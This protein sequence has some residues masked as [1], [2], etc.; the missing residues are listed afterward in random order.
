MLCAKRKKDIMARRKHPHRRELLLES[1]EDR[2]LCDAAPLVAIEQHTLPHANSTIH[3]T[4]GEKTAVPIAHPSATEPTTSA[5]LTDTQRQAIQDVVRD[6]TAQIWFEKNA[7]QF[8]EGV[9]FGFRTSFGSMMVYDDH[10]QIRANQTDPQTGKVGVHTVN[11]SFTGSNHSWQIVPGES[12]GVGGS[13][14]NADGTI[15]APDIFK[16]LTIRNVYEGVD[17]RLYSADKGTL[18]FDWLVARAQDYSKIR[19][20]FSGQDGMTFGNDGSMSLDLRFQDLSLKL[21][22][23]YQLVGGVKQ[24]HAAR[25]VAGTAPGEVR[26]AIEGDLVADAPLVIDPN[27]AWATYFDLND[28]TLPFDSYLFAVTAG[29][30][31]VYAFGWVKETITNAANGAYM[32]VPAGFSQGTAANQAYIYRLN[33]SGTNITA[34]TGTGITNNDSTVSNQALNGAGYD[35]PA[36]LEL[37]PDGRI[38]AGFN[39]GLIQIYSADLATRSYS[40]EPVTMDSLNS[41]AIVDNSSF[42][43]G[44]RVTAAIP[45]GQIAAANI[46]PDATFAGTYEGVIVRYSNA[47]TTPTANW[48]TYVGGNNSEYFTAIALTPDKT[49]LVFATTTVV[50]AAYPT[51]VNA[52]DSTLGAAGTTELL[53]GVLPEQATKPAAFS[54]FSY[55]GGSGNEG[56]L[57]TNTTAAVVT[58]T[59][60]FFYVAGNTAS[61]DLPGVTAATGGAGNGAQITNGGGNFDAFISLIP[62]NGSAGAGFQSTYVGGNLE[63]NIGGIAYDIRADRVLLFG[64][65]AGGTFPVLNTTPPSNYYD[66]TFGGGAWDIFVAT[67]TGNLRT[68]DFAT[69]IGG[70]SNDYLGQTGDLIG[71]GH[72]IYSAVTGLTYLATTVHSAD[73]PTS[74]I[75]TPPG[76]DTSKS[77]GTNDSHV[78]FAFNLNIFDYGDAPLTYDVNVASAAREGQSN[79][80]RLGALTD[81]ESA[82]ASGVTATGDD[83]LNSGTGDDEDAISVIPA[84]VVGDTGYSLSVSVFNNTG[85]ARTLNAWID[86]NRNGTFE[87]GEFATVSVPSSALQQTLTLAWATLPA[88][89]AGQSYIRLRL[90]DS[91][92]TDN[93]GTTTIDERSI[94]TG[95]FGEIEDYALT[96]GA[97]PTL[98]VSNV[99]TTEGT[100]NFAQFAVNLSSASSSATSL[101]FSLA[102]VTATGGGTDYGAGGAGNLQVST[103]GGVTWAN[104]TTVT[105]PAGAT[106]VLVRTPIVN[107]TLDENAETFTL[108]ATR[109]A[110]NTSNASAIGTATINDDDP[111][112]TIVINDVTVNE[113]AGTMT[114]TATLSAA[115]GLPVSVNYATSNGSATAGSDY[116]AT[117]G[118]LNFASGIVS[119]TITV[120]IANDTVFEGSETFNV[121]LSAAVNATIADNLGIGTI[122]DD[123]TGAG[124]TDND[125]PVLSV[126]SPT[127]TEGT[128]A[129]AIFTV[130]LS[131][132]STTAV[133]L[134]LALAN[135]S[136]LG[137]GVDYGASLEVSTNG[138]ATWTTASAATIAAGATSVLVRTPIVNDAL[139]EAAETFT[140]T[141]TRTAGTTTN[142]SATGTAT[143]VD[144]DPTPTLVINDVTV[145][146]GAGTMTFIVTLSAPSGQAVSVNYATLNGTA[147]AGADYTASSGTVNF[148]LGTTTQTIT[149]PI[150]ND[151]I[152]EQSENFSVLLSG[153]VNVVVA[154]GTGIGTILDDGTGGGATDNDTPVISVSNIVVTEGTDAFAIFTVS[155]SNPSTGTVSVNLALAN[156]SALG[157]GVDY[158]ASL[159]VSTNGGATWTTASAAT[160]AAGATSVL[161][162]TPIVN[163]ALNEASETFTLTATRT[164][165]TTTNAIAVGTAT[166][167]D[168]DPQPAFA[169]NDVTVNEAAGTATF[170]VTLSA[171]SGQAVS[172]NYATSNG[173]ALA[174]SDYTATSGVL[175]FAAGVT[176]QT[177]TVAITNDS[178]FEQSE[179]FNLNLSAAVNA[180]IADNLGIG[181]IKDDGTGAGGADNDTPTISVGNVTVTE[182]TDA[183][184]IF[185]VSLSNASATPVSVNLALANGSALGGGVDYG[186]SLEVSTNGG[187]TWTT[188]SAATIAAGSTSVLVRTPIVND[189]INEASETFT[190]TA[191]RTAGTTTNASAVGTATIVDNDPQPSFAINDVTVNEAAGTMTFTV[192]LSAPS[193][194]A[195]SVNYATSDGTALAGSDYAAAGGVL[196]F[197]AGVTSQTVTVSI[198]ND[199]I[200]EVVE[201]FRVNLSGAVN[202]TIAD[203]LGIGTIRDDGTGAGGTDNDTPTIN[204]ANVLVT[205]GTDPYAIFTVSLS[206]ASTAPVS[207]NLVLANGSALGGGVDYGASLEVSTDGGATWTTASSATIAAGSTS[208]LV[209]TPI[210]DDA[211]NE[212]AETF[213]LTAIRTAGTTTN[214]SVT[215]TATIADNDPKPT[216]T[217]NDVIVNE[218]AGT[219]TFTV[220]LSAPSGQAVS[221]SY[222]TSDGTAVVVNDYTAASGTLN[223]AP[224]VT[225]QTVTISIVDDLLFENSETFN[226][227][228]SGA[229]NA[230]LA[231]NL[232][233]GTIKDDGTGI[234][235]TNNDTPVLSVSSVTV[236]EGTDLYAVF[237][238]SL[239]N[240]STTAVGLNLA[241]GNVTATGGGSDYGTSGAGNLQVSMD[242]GA[243]WIDASS[244]TI[245]AGTAGFLARTPVANDNISEPIETFTL[246]ATVTSGT[247]TTPNATGTALVLDDE[248]PPWVTIDDVTVNEAAGNAVFTVTLQTPSSQTVT[249]DYATVSG[250][251]TAGADF[252]GKTGTLTFAPGVTTL[253]ISVPI[254]NDPLYEV[255]ENFTV[256]LSGAVHATVLDDTG[257]GTILDDGTGAGGTDDDMPSINVS[258]PTVTEGTN[259]FAVFTVSL[260]NPSTGVVSVN[261]ALT[262]GTATGLGTDYGPG[263][264]ISTD[265]GATW[266]SGSNATFAAG[267]TTVLARTA[268]TDDALD[269]AAETFTLTA[270]RSGGLTTNAVASGTA[271]ILDNDPTP[272][273]TI[274]DVTVNEAAGT[275]TFTVT[276]SAA[277]GQAVSVAY[278]TANGTATSG[279]DYSSTSGTLNFA[280]GVVS[281]TIVVSIA[282]DAVFEGSETFDVNLS[283][284]VNATI[285]DALGLGTI[286]DDGT[287]SGGVD[288]DTP[289][290]SVSSPTV[291]EGTD[292]FAVFTVSL[293]NAST[294]AVDLNLALA[295]G[296]ATGSD[297]GPGL[298]VSTDGGTT[299]TTASSATMAAGSMSL[300]VRTPITNDALDEAAETFTLTATRT[301][302]TTTN[303]SASGIGTIIDDDPTPSFTIN[304]VTV[305]E[306]TGTATFTVTLSAASGQAVSVNYATSD[307]SALAGADYT[308]TSGTL[309]FAT[310]VVS[311]TITVSILDDA[312]FENSEDFLVTLSGPVNATIVDNLGIGTIKD[313][314][315][316]TGGTDNDTPAVSVSNPNVREGTDAFAVFTVSLSHPSTTPVDVSL[317]LAN[318]TA[319]GG[320]TDFGA[321]MEISTDGGA[322]W[323]SGA[324][325]TFAAGTTDVLVRTP[326]LNDAL[327][328]G[329]ENFTLAATVTSGTT[330]NASATGTATIA[331]DDG[332]PTLSINDVTVN[333][334]AGTMTFTVTMS[335][336]SGLPV[337]VNYATASGT[338]TAGADFTSTSGTLIFAPGV[339]TRTIVVPILNDTIFENSESFSVLLSA[340]VNGAIGD[341]T[342]IGTIKDDGTGAGGVD[343]DTPALSVSNVAVTEGTN[344][345]AVFTVSLSNPS[346]TAVT[347]SLALANVSALGG[348]TD[349]GASGATNLQVST[350]GGTTWTNAT[351]ATI[352]A[353]STSVLVRTPIVDD[354]LDENAETFTLTA[355]VTSGT[356][357]GSPVTGTATITDNDPTPSL[358]INDV[359]VN[360]AAGT[361]TFTVTLSAPSGL[362]ASVNYTTSNGTATAGSDYTAVSGTLNFAPGTTTQTITVPILNDTIFEQSETFNVLLSGAVN[363]TIADATGIGTIKDDGTGTGGTDN[364]KPA[365]SVSNVTVLEGTDN[366]AVFTVNLG[367]TSTTPVTVSLAL[368]NGTATGADYGPAIQVSTDGGTTWTTTASA[369]IAAGSTSVLVRTPIVNDALD[370]AAETF[371]LI[372]TRTAGTTTNAS[373]TG[374]ATI[375]DDDP[376]PTMTVNDVTVNEGAGTLTFTVTLSAPSGQAVSVNYATASGT[377]TSGAD[378]TSASGTLNFALGVT[379]RTIT[380]PIVNDTLFEQSENFSLLLSSAVNATITDDTGI[381]TI[382]DDGTGPGGTN[383]DT[384]SITVSNP[385]ALEG[386]DLFAVFNVKLSNPSTTA[387]DVAFALADGTAVGGGT[388]YGST[389]EVSTDGG[390]TWT[391]AASATFAPGSTSVLVRT[392]VVDDALD[393]AA[394]TFTLT[395]T[396]TAGLTTNASA[397]GTGTIN[398]DDPPPT[399]TI[400]DVIVNEAAGFATFTVSLNT[401][402]GQGVSVNFATASGTATSGADFTS[403]SG[404]L[405]FVAGVTTQTIDVPI[406][407]DSVFEKTESFSVLLTGPVHATI[408]DNL[409]VGTILDDGTGPGGTDDDTPTIVVSNVTV[410]EGTDAYAVFAVSLSNPVKTAIT[411]SFTLADGTAVGGGTDYGATLEVSDDGGATWTTMGDATFPPGSTSVLV[412]TPIT[413]DAL[414]EA[415]ENF[416]LTATRTAGTTTNPSAVGVATI[417]DNDP[418]PTIR[419]ND[420]TV[421]EAAG[422]A[423]FTVSLNAPSGQAVSVNYATS[424][425]TATAGSDYTAGSG[426]LNF[427][428]GVTSQT[429]TISITNDTTFEVSENF[430]VNLSSAVRATIADNLGVGTIL[431]DGTGAGGTDNDTPAITVN[432]VSVTE[433]TNPYAVFSVSLSNP[434]KT[435][436]SVS[437]ALANGSAVGGG[438]DF[439][440]ALEVSTN[441]GTTWVAA[442]NATIAAGSTSVL[443]R[444]PIV[445]DALDEAAET[446]TLTATR[447]VG[448]TTN[449]SAI[450][451]ATII[452]DDPPPTFSITDV[453][454][455]EGA[456]TASFVVSLNTP[457]GQ[458]VSV[459]YLTNDGTAL[460]GS[461]YTATSGVLNFT[462]GVTSQTVTV[463]IAND[464][465]FEQSEAFSVMLNGAVNATITKNLGI[466]IILDDGTGA[467]GTDNDT[468]TIGVTNVTVL[469][470]TDP[471][472][473]FAVSLSRVS[474]TAVSVNLALAN[475][476]ATGG[477]VDFGAALEV[478]SDGGTTWVSASSV[479]FSPG[480]TS[481]LV[482]TPIT[483]DALNEAAETFTL[484]ATRTAGTTINPSA[485]GT[486]T[487]TDNDPQP[488]LTIDD[489]VVNEGIGTATF[490]V[491]MSA[492]SGQAVSVNYATANGT[493]LAGTDFAAATGTLTFPAGSL[494]QTVTIPIAIFNDGIFEG[495]EN[496]SM[497]LS[498]AVNATIADGTGSGTILDAGNGTG[499]VDND[500]PS[501]SVGNAVALEGTDTHLVF[502]V[503]LT[504]PSTTAVTVNLALANGTATGGGV[505]FGP[506][507][508]VSTDGGTTWT[509]ASSATFAPLAT[510]VLVR[511]PVINDAL[512]EVAENLTLT[513]TRTAGTT[514]NASATGIGTITDDDGPPDLSI[515]DVTVNEA[516][517]TAT[518]T[519][520]LSVPSGQAVS[521]NF[522]SVDGTAQS[523]ADYTGVS[524]TLNFAA[525]VTSQTITVP[526]LNDVV[527]ERSENFFIQLSGAVN[528]P[529][530]DDIGVGTILDDGTG[531]G[532]TDNDTPAISVSSPNVT[533]GANPFA[534]FTVALSRAST[535]PV[536]ASF[537]LANG[538]AN[539]G[540]DFGPG[541][542]VSLD[543]GATWAAVANATFAP[544]NT[545]VLVRTPVINDALNEQTETFQLTATRTAGTT[546]NASATGTGTIADDDAPPAILINDVTVNEA[547]GTA[548]F[549]VTL[550]VPSALAVSVNYATANGT[551]TAGA[552]FSA[553]SG[554]LNFAAGVTSQTITVPILNDTIFEQS[555]TFNVL[556]SAAVNATIADATGVG[557]IV[558]DGTGAGG[559]DN[560]TPSLNVVNVT[561]TEG[562]NPY[563]V[564]T[565]SLSNAST[566]PVSV[567]LALATGTA[568]GADFGPGLEVSTNGG[569][570]W[571]VAANATI[572]P[573]STS[574]LVRTPVVND[575]LDENAEDFTLTAT[576]TAGITTNAGATGTGTILDDDPTPSLNV[577]SPTVLEGTDTYAIFTVSLSSR[578]GAPVDVNLALA[579]GTATGGGTDFGPGLEVST[580]GGA[581]W[582]ASASATIASGTTSVLV[583]TPIADDALNEGTENFTLTA[584]RSAGTTLNAAATGTA[585]ILDDDGPPTVSIGDVTVNESA[586]TATFAVTLSKVSG[587]AIAVDYASAD[588]SARNGSDYAGVS[589]T[590]NFAT[591]VTSLT[592]VVPI[593]N[594]ARYENRETFDINLSNATN[595]LIADGTGVGTVLDDDLPQIVKTLVATSSTG[596]SGPNVVP[597]EVVTFQLQFELAEGA[598]PMVTLHD[599]L[600]AGL[601]MLPDAPVLIGFTNVATSIGGRAAGTYTNTTDDALISASLTADDDNFSDGTGVFFKLGTLTNNDHDADREFV[602]VQFSA[603]VTNSSQNQ[604]GF[605]HANNF[606]ALLDTNG[607]GTTGYVSVDRNGDNSATGTEVAA[608][609]AN[610]GSGTAGVSKT[611]T[612]TLA[613]AVLSLQKQITSAPAVIKAGDTLTYTITVNHAVGSNA[614][615]WDAT[616]S[617]AIPAGMQVTNI[618]STTVAGGASVQAPA[619]ISGGGTGLDGVFDIPV[620]GSVTVV[621][622]ATVQSSAVLGS[623]LNNVADLTWSSLAGV[624]A[625]ERASGDGLLNAGGLNDYE[626]QRSATA[627]V[628]DGASEF[629]I[630]KRVVGDLNAEIGERLHFSIT[631]NVADGV[632]NNLSLADALPAGFQL[633]AGSASLTTS[634]G[635]SV[636]SA[637]FTYAASQLDLAIGSV[638]S[639]VDGRANT[640][641]ISYDADVLDVAGNTGAALKTN[642]ATASYD[643]GGGPIVRTD[644]ETLTV[645][646][647]TLKIVKTMDDTTPHFGQVVT[648]TITITHAPGSN[649]A[650]HDLVLADVLPGEVS[651]DAASIQVSGASVVTNTSVNG[652]SLNLRLDQLA[653]GGTATITYR[654]KVT[655]DPALI[656]GT[657]GGGDDDFT[658]S[659]NLTYDTQAGTPV[660]ER[661][662]TTSTSGTATLVGADLSVTKDDGHATATPGDRLVYTITVTNHGTAAATNVI[663]RDTLPPQVAT[664]N[665]ALSSAGAVVANGVA[666]F[667]IPSLAAGAT[668]TLTVV[669]DLRAGAP[670]GIDSFTNVVN[671]THADLDPTPGDNT[672]SDNDAL[673]AAPDYTISK[674]DGRTQ[675]QPGDTLVYTITVANRGN[676]AGTGIIVRD[677]FATGI[678]SSVVAS[679]G[680]AVDLAAG[681]VTWDLAYLG[682]GETR[683]LSLTARVRSSFGDFDAGAGN[684]LIRDTATVRDDGRNGID[685]TPAGNR[686]TDADDL[687]AKPELRVTND[688]GVIVVAP[689]QLVTYRIVAQNAGGQNSHGTVVVSALPEGVTFVSATSTNPDLSG[690]PTGFGNHVLWT[691]TRPLAPGE[692]VE[693]AIVVRADASLTRGAVLA[694]IAAISDDG[695]YGPDALSVADNTATD[696]D[697][698]MV[699]PPIVPFVYAYDSF[700]DFSHESQPPGVPRDGLL[701]ENH[702]GVFNRPP[703]L[704][705]MPIYS[706]EADPGATLVVSVFNV[707]GE[708][709]GSQTVVVDAGGNWMATFPSTTLNDFPSHVQ[710]TE[711]PAPYS[712]PDGAGHNLRTYFSPAIN[713]GHFFTESLGTDMLSGR[714]APLLGGLGLENPLQLGSVKYGGELLGTQSTASG[715]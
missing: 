61:T 663:V 634:T 582:T 93:A 261:L 377:A 589:G 669:L 658:N 291:T 373:A 314:G 607:D 164:A 319:T 70:S 195:A 73:I 5:P 273:L 306:A 633:V 602:T 394:E 383:N 69:Y 78:V 201:N 445:N 415:S 327:N 555:E 132:A 252:T 692:T 110:G 197:A 212:A 395:A 246:T 296:T 430:N 591:G 368:A 615:A 452:D 136:A 117:N 620:G 483:D 214:A 358:V 113:A 336:S 177:V 459:N 81:T 476:S 684:Q 478:S 681:T 282:N 477:G 220:L 60:S 699:E 369:T 707:R 176:T 672:A 332:P 239:S 339:L 685:P 493:A 274:N 560:D 36:D 268:I 660:N 543:G 670:A 467:G 711:I 683:S 173:T 351:T 140:L 657:F 678:F 153:P 169:I 309:N 13:Y 105:L 87:V 126:S 181:T 631:V 46:G 492:P 234:G 290:I 471:Y 240:L 202:A 350:N 25:M 418:P 484:T 276:L 460:A 393:E 112:P 574:V 156:G 18:E 302:G 401:P 8:A 259:A 138:G 474:T 608:D 546:T 114:F 695:R 427:A 571:V 35:T 267:T 344:P 361:M 190:L 223:F 152:F 10:L 412:R 515:N 189:A 375:N 641:T 28:S 295:D 443:V 287:G 80:L 441:G 275:A 504:N 4:T 111:T 325:A 185:T 404:T 703:L 642:T 255:S 299:W 462:P 701:F 85:A 264:E 638:Q 77:N 584:T 301:A 310:G 279:A 664:L 573:G 609:P 216:L 88:L 27:V 507:L 353:G 366:F 700:H 414:N 588:G 381:G 330:T 363:A 387:V 704:P 586:G 708:P 364:D 686:A 241:L 148:A 206:N 568:S 48:A 333:E 161:V 438:V 409:G 253:T 115:S 215:G 661:T 245:A 640:L 619:I 512:D 37:F 433:G 120:P 324:S 300:L 446:F 694:N 508:Q 482:R 709:I 598:N 396:R 227:N 413:D 653:V 481:V 621:Y 243:T 317:A 102:N 108:T 448:T 630:D 292:A 139:D 648:Y 142:A 553:R 398:D 425:G 624:D 155:L 226:V 650:A 549:T 96:I 175:N 271:T 599:F 209:R 652:G 250:T 432:S 466:G 668:T 238:V 674:T 125:T 107:D 331:D 154:D 56:T 618:V 52:I 258:S 548:T 554:T 521:V 338:A 194:Q 676:Q 356:A 64:T 495:S 659:V 286:K 388:D 151:A 558:D 706:G 289:T 465:I 534:V 62:L 486:A 163:D 83:L 547:A 517:G 213:T 391:A 9:R 229:V 137:G 461:D 91:A 141:A 118:T 428:P 562:A 367:N 714:A 265:G 436:V 144:D 17:L 26:Y 522:A 527:F 49:K 370:E 298:E 248:G 490:T 581:T 644:S 605:A 236:T 266:T 424:N 593:T 440:P 603:L 385:T 496:F 184:A 691:F 7:G 294:T 84:L 143:I 40:A 541:L 604:A 698:A 322:T 525:G 627:T 454:V 217:I 19:M 20:V 528:A 410:A 386:T 260:S 188:A 211:L 654:A 611:V 400:D 133:S 228:L 479:T 451:T 172:V 590:L 329:T 167:T 29:A 308:G 399:I 713:P 355:A 680:G 529:I 431:D 101:S 162:R 636:T 639:A 284:V 610:D 397:V 127:V 421:N 270:T 281:Q 128:D 626:L 106:S 550:N 193:G 564:F 44:G 315:T 124:G 712:L 196:N 326:I 426:V 186:A 50:G 651:L 116:T 406:V 645:A 679:D 539:S 472:A 458:P 233:V 16:E 585:T 39:S 159:E 563:A 68:K 613:E 637:N 104:G 280:P 54:V 24:T 256:V 347:A 323:T 407:N 545:S 696:V 566:T 587:L 629:A 278:A 667:T 131:N 379:T 389:L 230:T 100:D 340:V 565:V 97:Q 488:S 371:T 79:A 449:A 357:T 502:T 646:E 145:N 464:A 205:E 303:A 178:V 687:V 150:L 623:A 677:T 408:A 523:T 542:E 198:T 89:T 420:V 715:Y 66:G 580:D 92:L 405:N 263:L 63:D 269:E 597:G 42:Y 635:V 480:S 30:N 411:L 372:A 392:P 160:I 360:E 21:P 567:S 94:G 32:E 41:L 551:A 572:A 524:G 51:L 689:G 511:T 45:V 168:N 487:I 354:A 103:D 675:A 166:I 122:K 182:G 498:N 570:T 442:A 500:T 552:D 569:T 109:T 505:D 382:L 455:N 170:T 617:D 434:S 518:F 123:G 72:V 22:E 491:T 583:R 343:N 682:S 655:S 556:L 304:D 180:T 31:G 277:S 224:G 341:N 453:T 616:L 671:V 134:N 346:T 577:S 656:G 90:T 519:V 403:T 67:F 53:V 335:Q 305:N 578:S 75:G 456:G 662:S 537:A 384:P 494:V 218:G 509:T 121:N 514:L 2:I 58:A 579:N 199:T 283:G 204:V 665:R 614:T 450:G 74:A 210:T 628:G 444:T 647:P 437:L 538:T 119:Q 254:V 469:E 179:T 416:T 463:T 237:S 262:N 235:G 222:A 422:T 285:A 594:D 207:V 510:T 485:T 702:A 59:D 57:A 165:G 86:F 600:P 288:N 321:G 43:V 520:S 174:G 540:T 513:A 575:L 247:T 130:S 710:I 503:R 536:S 439:G 99:V 376:T 316:G 378:F 334:A 402:S 349:Y 297:F 533:E 419:I 135:G 348:G 225:S 149:V 475:G 98:N 625:N 435:P 612:T 352:A 82:P 249:V 272:S 697:V 506:G 6:S 417:A 473:I 622:R 307:G 33:N 14:Q 293:S 530:A 192:T 457:S 606:A 157:G 489:I 501:L 447:T 643:V 576:R 345:F 359:T 55:L 374:T 557:T 328:E 318:G 649:A 531:A 38:L 47:T 526:I 532:G 516:A 203:N 208:V 231:D 320:G 559:A 3:A 1:F 187:T 147:T 705:L 693:F 71:Q 242:G 632:L 221:V 688:D 200:F 76:K 592:V 183:F 11:V 337:S 535:T 380:V 158:G 468:P 313:D 191:T 365:L 497:L 251:A 129:F 690:Q 499:G 561:V 232:G 673:V 362:A 390:A 423:T 23:T 666:S 15:S 34:W 312:I 65:T 595:A 146:E 12:S 311:Q 429:V 544:G 596:S 257:V 95:N 342:G 219:A 470:G 171:A 244:A 601:Q